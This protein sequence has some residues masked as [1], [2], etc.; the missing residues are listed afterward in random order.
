MLM[1]S[2]AGSCSRAEE[3]SFNIKLT[4][5]MAITAKDVEDVLIEYSENDKPYILIVLS[6]EAKERVL[7]GNLQIRG[8]F[9]QAEAIKLVDDIQD[10]VFGETSTYDDD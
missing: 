1:I 4:D 3:P 8:D 10:S 9:T 6:Q 2:V 5:S 7:R